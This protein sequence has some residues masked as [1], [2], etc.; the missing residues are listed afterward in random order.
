MVKLKIF[1]SIP[2]IILIFFLYI[3]LGRRSLC[4]GSIISK[5]KVISAAHCVSKVHSIRIFYGFH[6]IS[7][8]RKNVKVENYVIHEDYKFPAHDIAIITVAKP[9]EFSSTIGQICLPTLLN[10]G[11]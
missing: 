1:K 4:G 10:E 5:T 11:L 2:N 7:R 9:F 6:E 8:A 3:Y